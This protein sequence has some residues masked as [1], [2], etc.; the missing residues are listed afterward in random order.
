VTVSSVFH[1]NSTVAADIKDLLH[2]LLFKAAFPARY[3][4]IT[5][6]GTVVAVRTSGYFPA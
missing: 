5:F 1:E 3:L 6:G 4:G 2:I